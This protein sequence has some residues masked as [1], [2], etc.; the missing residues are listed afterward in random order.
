MKQAIIDNHNFIYYL[1]NL[2]AGTLYGLSR[3]TT[4]SYQFWNI[5]IWFGII[6]ATWIYLISKKTTA[7]V[8]LLSV[9]IF[10]Y[11]FAVRT[12]LAWFD[13][14][15]ILLNKIGHLIHCDYKITSVI[16]CVFL[17]ALVYLLLFKIFT[18]PKTFKR[19][20]IICAIIAGLVILLFPISNMLFKYYIEQ[21]NKY[22]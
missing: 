11:M 22:N 19:V 15:V 8:N 10:I 3:A 17:T 1:F 16:V 2:T 18:S 6:P 9:A 21:N 4:L 20:L 5:L 14:A 7:W 12:W 13:K